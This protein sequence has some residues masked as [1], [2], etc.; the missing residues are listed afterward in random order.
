MRILGRI[1]RPLWLGV[2]GVI[3]M[4][5]FFVVLASIPLGQIVLLTIVV[6]ILTVLFV[7]RSLRV[8]SELSDRGG[9]PSLRRELNRA[10]E[11]RGFSPRDIECGLDYRIGGQ[12]LTRAAITSRA[13]PRCPFPF[14]L[15]LPL[16]RFVARHSVRSRQP[17]ATVVGAR[18]AGSGARTRSR[19]RSAVGA[20]SRGLMV[21]LR[22]RASSGP[23]VTGST[24]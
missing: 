15:P 19:S 16:R 2:L 23:P 13:A 18:S 6:A 21:M 17:C 4:S 24:L 1:T 10:R 14:A 11:R 22:R 3:V 12:S 8:A 7:I 20:P 5:M 9:D